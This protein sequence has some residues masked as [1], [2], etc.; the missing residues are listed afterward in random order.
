MNLLT[1]IRNAIFSEKNQVI[2]EEKCQKREQKRKVTGW[3]CLLPV[4]FQMP[5]VPSFLHGQKEILFTAWG[6]SLGSR[7]H[8]LNGLLESVMRLCTAGPA[9][10]LP[11]GAPAKGPCGL[12]CL[13]LS[14]ETILTSDLHT[15]VGVCSH[16]CMA[17][18]N[19]EGHISPVPVC[20]VSG[21]GKA[22]GATVRTMAGVW[23]REVPCAHTR[24]KGQ[25]EQITPLQT[26]LPLS[27]PYI[28]RRTTLKRGP[29]LVHEIIPLLG[30]HKNPAS[31]WNLFSFLGEVAQGRAS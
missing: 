12:S 13:C 14:Q 7:P 5:F 31:E 23:S 2:I 1:R 21:R 20:C 26:H 8:R 24:G 22:Q 15:R 10:W 18:S 29:T 17:T 16:L 27:L 4:C 6:S 28:C 9:G 30:G 25:Q 3:Q 11:E 19:H